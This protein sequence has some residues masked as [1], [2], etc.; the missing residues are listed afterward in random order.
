MIATTEELDRIAA[1]DHPDPHSVLG[2]HEEDGVLVVR[3]FRPDALSVRLIPEGGGTPREMTRVHGLGIFEARMGPAS[4]P[5]SG[6]ASEPVSGPLSGPTSPG[7]PPSGPTSPGASGSPALGL[8]FLYKIEVQY[9]GTTETQ[10][11]P[12]AFPAGLGP[13][14]LHLAAEGTHLEIYRRLGAHVREVGGVRG[15]GFAVWA[16]SAQRVSVAGDFNGWDGRVAAM[17]RIGHGIWEIFLPGVAEGALYKFEIKTLQ[18]PVV[19]KCDPYGQAMELRPRTASRVVTRRYEFTDARWVADRAAGE[20]RRRPMS[21][22]EVHLGSWRIRPEPSPASADLARTG[23]PLPLGE[24]SGKGKDPAERWYGYREIADM[25]VDYVADMGFTH[26]E[27]LPVMEHP[28]DGSWGYQVSGYFAPTS[29]YGD[30]DDLRYLVDRFHSR[31]IGVILDWTPAHFPKD[32]FAL[33]R[34]DGSALYEHLD[35]R[36]GEHKHWNTFVFNYGRPEVKNFLI[37][38]AL[39]WIDEF[40]VD[41]LRVDAVASMLYLDYGASG[42]GDWVPNRFGGRENLEAVAFLRELNERVHTLYPGVV[43]AAEEST[44]WPGVTKPPYVGGLGFDV[45]WNMGWMRDTLDYF[46]FDPIFRAYHHGKLTFSIWYAFNERFLLPLSHDE[47]VH[48]KKAL[49]SKMPGDR[50][51]MHGN[52][53][54]LYA[55]MWAHPGKKLLFMGGE[56]GQYREWSFEGELDWSLLDEPSHRGI[57]ALVRDLNR[58]YQKLPAMF[59]LDDEPEG[60]RWIDCNDAPHSVIAFVRFPSFLSAKGRRIITDKGVHVVTVCN[61]TPVPRF[62]YRIGVPR[63]SAYLERLNT[64]AAEYGGSGLGNFGR[65]EV[66]DVPCHGFAQSVVLTLPP[67]STL[68]FVPELVEDPLPVVEERGVTLAHG[69]FAT[70]NPTV[71]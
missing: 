69:V 43:V 29:R 61:F 27:L 9:A 57:Q 41:G 66:E 54:A 39:Y 36:K 58:L 12:Y 15:T 4:A 62:E 2:P 26:V 67:L 25:L 28:Y 71:L 63:R 22:Y 13:L 8:P 1:V 42:P 5:P 68:W 56:I 24:T 38:N 19:L 45:K 53:R 35:P 48:L 37:S 23:A 34:F 55:Y 20:A 40:H 32:A 11:D 50:E 17:R 31:G 14:D 30:P 52:L 6:P 49:L 51:A 21:I 70:P 33:G 18:G 47:V 46:G 16:P 7:V 3:V 59:E 64:D 60:F 65:V 44:S 10:H